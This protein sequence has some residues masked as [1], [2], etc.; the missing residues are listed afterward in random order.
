MKGSREGP[1]RMSIDNILNR[2]TLNLVKCLLNYYDSLLDD[3]VKLLENANTEYASLNSQYPECL[4][5]SDEQF[6][7]E[8]DAKAKC[9]KQK[10]ESSRQRKLQRFRDPSLAAG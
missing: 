2:A 9:Y 3:E 10:L 1:L 7:E 5:P 4:D 8:L 6:R